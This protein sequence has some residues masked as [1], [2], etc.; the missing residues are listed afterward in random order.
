[1]KIEEMGWNDYFQ[2]HFKEIQNK[3]LVPGR[4]AQEQKGIYTVLY[5][6]G[7]LTA[8]ISGKFRYETID[9]ENFPAVG[10]WVTIECLPGNKEALIHKLLPRKTK[11][12]RKAVL[13]GGMPETGGRTEAQVLAAN[14]DTV[15]L[16]NGLDGDF[17]IRRIERYMTIVWDS[18]ANPVVILNKC[19]LCDDV[20]S[21]I[22]EVEAAFIGVPVIAVS[23]IMR[24]GFEGLHKYLAPGKTV[25]FLGSS[26]VGKST[27]VNG[28]LGYDRQKTSDV[29]EF[30]DRG[31]HTTTSRE[32]IQLPC[33][34]LVID[35]PGIREIQMWTDEEGISRTFRDIEELAGKCRF[36]NCRHG[37]E[38]GCAVQRAIKS[39]DLDSRRFQSY[40]KLQKE[41]AHLALRQ[42]KKAQRRAERDWFKKIRHDTRLRARLRNKGLL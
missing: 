34:S 40:L 42:D 32:M 28:L 20:D 33:G 29:R 13:S 41:A 21:V 5:A 36:G 12:S 26:G 18:G 11:F 6:E 38:P 14:I 31:K 22:Q 19:D 27:I 35:T 24:L 10:D 23:A 37:D 7:S 4:I 25:V 8:R 17:N 2:Q 3:K 9:Y 39:G 30:K 1:M 15:F 16:V